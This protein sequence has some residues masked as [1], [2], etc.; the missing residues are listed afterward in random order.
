MQT[1]VHPNSI[2]NEIAQDPEL[3]EQLKKLVLERVTAMPDSLN[4]A[5]GSAEITKAALIKAVQN[6][7]EIGRQFMEME[8]EFSRDLGSGAVY[9]GQ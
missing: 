7:D 4:L 2:I 6:E 8:L 1:V 5:V 3:K 9:A